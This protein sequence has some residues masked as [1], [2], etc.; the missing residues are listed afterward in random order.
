MKRYFEGEKVLSKPLLWGDPLWREIGGGTLTP[1]VFDTIAARLIIG[2]TDRD[3]YPKDDRPTEFDPT[4]EVLDE[5]V[6]FM[7]SGSSIKYYDGEPGGQP[8]PEIIDLVNEY[9]RRINKIA[10][11][12]EEQQEFFSQATE[13]E[14][15]FGNEFWFMYNEFINIIIRTNLINF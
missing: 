14:V 6:K 11:V 12:Y 8:D 5:V 7:W 1:E 13:V 9:N 15:G 3:A 4:S 10:Q 2:K